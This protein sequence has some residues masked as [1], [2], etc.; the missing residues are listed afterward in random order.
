MTGGHIPVIALFYGHLEAVDLWHQ[1]VTQYWEEIDLPSS[2]DFVTWCK[3]LFNC[4]CSGPPLLVMLGQHSKAASWFKATGFTWDAQGFENFNA[5]FTAASRMYP[6]I[7]HTCESTALRLMIFLAAPAG[8][9]GESEVNEWIPSPA[10]L[11]EM[12][13]RYMWTRRYFLHDITSIGALAFLKLGRNDDAY[14]LAQLAVA[15]KQETEKK[16]TL[17]T[18]HSILGQV[19]AKRGQMEDADNH[20]VRALEEAKLIRLPMLEVLAARDWKKHAL[21]GSGRDGYPADLVIDEAC[22]RM[23]KTREQVASVLSA[24]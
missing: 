24:V 18:C 2:G 22:A 1:K 4:L 6:T 17:V 13:R 23:K 9:I 19:T 8:A 3:E 5:F 15:S 14:E 10:V 20:F 11:A 7:D 21:E 12:E 16:T